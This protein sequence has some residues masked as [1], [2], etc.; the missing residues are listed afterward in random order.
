[1]KNVFFA[2]SIAA[3]L[4]GF[5]GCDKKN[6]AEPQKV[7]PPAV[8]EQKAIKAEPAPVKQEQKAEQMITGTVRYVGL[9]GGFYELVADDGEKYD[10]LN[11]PTEYKKDGLR[12]KF[13]IKEKKDVVGFHMRGKIVEVVT[14]ERLE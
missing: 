6:R 4:I 1:M 5:S 8:T 2:V 7:D 14:I 13:Q 12:V 3:L 9:E 10:P 11:L